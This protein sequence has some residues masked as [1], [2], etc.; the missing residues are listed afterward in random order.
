MNQILETDNKIHSFDTLKIKIQVRGRSGGAPS[1]RSTGWRR[2]PVELQVRAAH[3]PA[4]RFDSFRFPSLG[5][6][7]P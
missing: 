4:P 5:T 7:N 2:N 3:V 6:S 1:S